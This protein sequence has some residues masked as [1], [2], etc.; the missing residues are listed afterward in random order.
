VPANLSPEYRAAEE[1]YRKARDP[2][3][4]LIHLRE[5]LRTIPKHKG[6]E[7]LQADIKTRIKQATED[8][9]GPRKGG[10]RGGLAITVRPEGAAQI[11]LLG[12]PNSG[13][14]T[15][16]KALTGSQAEVG[17]YPFTTRIPMPGMLLHEDV[18][19]QLIDLPPVSASF[20]EPWT[21]NSLQP[22]DAALLIVDL[23]DPECIEHVTAIAERLAAKRISLVD[24][25]E[26]VEVAA[27]EE[28][29][30]DE[31]YDP[32]AIRLPTLLVVSKCELLEAPEREL[33]VLR[34]LSGATYPS[35]VVSADKGIGT[36]GI[37]ARLF[38][39]LGVVRVYSKVPGKPA[40]LS[41]PFTVRR[42]D[43]VQDVA[44]LVHRGL[45]GDLKTARLWGD[46][47][48][49]DGQQ[50]SREHPLADRDVLELSF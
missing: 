15:L 7:H 44:R 5:M 19:F 49:F 18:Q 31:D 38:E 8:S 37:S 50:V 17:P 25:F 33:E 3:E 34:E 45:A 26:P 12:P 20:M 11:A 46:G 6:T 27:T 2:D 4:R 43:T 9:A 30:E 28:A 40:D 10:A 42:G 47:A 35:L 21:P 39:L 22:A 36:D 14:S 1:A 32:F 29:L 41:R 24:D 16:H 23:T 48:Q 13:K